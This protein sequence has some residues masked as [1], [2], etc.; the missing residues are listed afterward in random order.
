[1]SSSKVH[2][3]AILIPGG[4][5]LRFIYISSE[6][7]L[8]DKKSLLDADENTPYPVN[9]SSFY[10]KSKMLAEKAL[11][12]YEGDIERIILR[13]TFIWGEDSAQLVDLINLASKGKFPWMDKGK[14]SFEHVYVDNVVEAIVNSLK[15]GKNNGIYLITNDEPMTAKTF[16]ETIFMQAGV[17]SPTTSLPSRPLYVVARLLENIWS[18]MKLKG[19]PPLTRFEIEFLSLTRRYN[20]EKAKSELKYKPIVT[21]DQ[22]VSRISKPD[23]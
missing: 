3:A 13:P 6:S 17:Q 18:T 22:G 5:V 1:M 19:R 15:Y 11:L 8:Q 10:G 2:L 21:F 20:I 14:S 4:N 9:P 23:I 12:E 7:V 16:F